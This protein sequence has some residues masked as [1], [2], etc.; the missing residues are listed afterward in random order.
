MNAKADNSRYYTG[1][2]DGKTYRLDREYRGKFLDLRE[3]AALFRGRSIELHGLRRG[4]TEYSIECQLVPDEVLDG[5]V[6]IRAVGTVGMN[7]DYRLDHETSP[8]RPQGLKE[9]V[10]TGGNLD[11]ELL[12]R[13]TRAAVLGDDVPIERPGAGLY[14]VGPRA[15]SGSMLDR[16]IRKFLGTLSGTW[17]EALHAAT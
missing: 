1:V 13:E 17:R 4:R 15:S 3:C 6:N 7:R 2:L 12:D 5:V 14:A 8:F 11:S 16:D 10:V 9:A